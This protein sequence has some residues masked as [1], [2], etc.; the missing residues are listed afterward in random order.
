MTTAAQTAVNIKALQAVF[1]KVTRMDPKEPVYMKLIA[2][3]DRCDDEALVT[4]YR[5][6]IKFV[7]PLALN[8]IIKRGIKI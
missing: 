6:E 5:A 8:R 1:G 7:S 2:L 4:V 3:L